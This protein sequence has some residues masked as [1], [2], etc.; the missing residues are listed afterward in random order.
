MKSLKGSKT[1]ENLLNSF[2]N[3]SQARNKY[4]FYSQVAET[5]GFNQISDIFKLTA[6]NEQGH[7]RI[8]FDFLTKDFND[9]QI[10]IAADYSVFI[11]NTFQ[12]LEYS[13]KSEENESSN[14]Y[15]QYENIAKSEGFLAVAN[16]F[17]KIATIEN[18]HKERFLKLANNIKYNTVFEKDYKEKWI[19]RFCGYIHEGSES[20]N[21][22]PFCQH[23][24]SYYEVCSERY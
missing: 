3:E 1:A 10:N 21:Q 13:A 24:Q 7:A 5:E 22:C 16:A 17:N 12:N 23:P 19:C 20:P 14:V 6:D 15:F 18:H 8:F 9:I 4:I 2:A 11:G